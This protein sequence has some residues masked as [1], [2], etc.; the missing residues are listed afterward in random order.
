MELVKD[1]KTSYQDY[2]VIREIVRK[3][4]SNLDVIVGVC[5]SRNIVGNRKEV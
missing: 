2:N 3:G 5:N 4:Y 1:V